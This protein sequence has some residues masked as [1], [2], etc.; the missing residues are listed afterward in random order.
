MNQA[1]VISDPQNHIFVVRNTGFV[2]FAVQG[3]YDVLSIVD[4]T[5]LPHSISDPIMN[6]ILGSTHEV[7]MTSTLS[8]SKVRD[9][10]VALLYVLLKFLRLAVTIMT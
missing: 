10:V 7:R 3:T 9:Y 1:A 6:T 2:A 8:A 5:H 4:Q